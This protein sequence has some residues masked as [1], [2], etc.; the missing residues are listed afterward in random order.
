MIPLFI[1]LLACLTVAFCVAQFFAYLKAKDQMHYRERK[2]L[3]TR[4]QTPEYAPMLAPTPEESDD[5]RG[6]REEDE[7]LHVLGRDT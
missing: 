6:Y 2:E 1:A 3:I 4:V 7:V 5:S